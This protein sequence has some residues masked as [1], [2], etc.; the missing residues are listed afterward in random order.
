VV[1]PDLLPAEMLDYHHQRHTKQDIQD[2]ST[3]SLSIDTLLMKTEMQL[4]ED[5]LKQ[6]KGN[7]TMAAR[8]LG[9]SRYSLTRRLKK[10]QKKT[11]RQET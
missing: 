2:H 10:I 5:V 7:K 11:H 6:T 9:I 4:I 3:G 8:K 1:D